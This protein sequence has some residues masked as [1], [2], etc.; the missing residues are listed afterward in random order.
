MR[1]GVMGPLLRSEFETQLERAD[2]GVLRGPV[3]I[4]ADGSERIEGT[5]GEGKTNARVGLISHVGGHKFAGNVIVSIPPSLKIGEKPHPL[6]GHGIWYG[7]VEPKHVEGLI[8]E[9]ILSGNVVSDLFRGGIDPQ[10]KIL[11]I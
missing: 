5:V 9:T 10:R 11:R 6:A 7:R 8:K 1:C 3:Q 2:V 4:N